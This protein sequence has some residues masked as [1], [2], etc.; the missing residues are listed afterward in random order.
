MI[1]AN[2]HFFFVL[3][4]PFIEMSA[5]APRQ[6]N[7][8]VTEA[9]GTFNSPESLGLSPQALDWENIKKETRGQR[10]QAWSDT[11]WPHAA[12]GIADR[13][14]LR[15]T[16]MKSENLDGRNVLLANF[17]EQYYRAV[18]KNDPKELALL[19]PAEKYDFL[20][21]QKQ[22]PADFITKN[23]ALTAKYSGSK[24]EKALLSLEDK[25]EILGS[26]DA[27]Y[28]AVNQSYVTE[29]KSSA[30]DFKPLLR[31]GSAFNSELKNYLPVTSH[32]W[33]L[34]LDTFSWAH[35]DE[36][37]WMGIC[38]GWSPAAL[39]EAK[40]KQS[41]MVT[42]GKRKI[43]LTEG[44]IRGLL[45]WTWG[46][47]FPAATLGAGIRCDANQ[48]K[49]IVK[50]KRVV[51]GR[52]C[53]G[54]G[55]RVGHCVSA[56][57]I[58]IGSDN[59]FANVPG[60]VVKFGFDPANRNSHEATLRNSLGNAYF[61][62]DVKSLSN[63]ETKRLL[64]QLTQSCRD[65][66]PGLFHAALVDLVA[67]KKIGF[68]VDADRYTQV[69]NQPVYAYE[70]TY[71][72]ILKRD[73]TAAPAGEPVAIVEVKNDPYAKFRSDNA[74]K[75]VQ[76]RTKVIYAAENGPFAIYGTDGRKEIHEEIV[77]DYTLEID[78]SGKIIGGEWGLLPES[79]EV[80]PLAISN[81]TT[82][83]APDFIWNYPDNS[84]PEGTLMNYSLIKKIHD[85]STNKPPTGRF[86]LSPFV[87][88]P[89]P[90]ADCVLPE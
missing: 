30:P 81:S 4:L 5:C 40:P 43:L 67:R 38:N 19:S 15:K 63:G 74:N 60:R 77:N 14:V 16:K 48:S 90:Y 12:K 32:D 44:D 27:T 87:K 79:P 1:R 20:V 53:E 62:A 71:L 73:G 34:W 49:T 58:Y 36:W 24:A 70:M 28:K 59:P 35:D 80:K 75:I 76:V 61:E 66:N 83:G 7:S 22:I 10:P 26:A 89:L 29:A 3:L 86:D 33:G 56:N 72:P 45:S 65:M 21:S 18:Q 6:F 64:I 55:S 78:K 54:K 52:L 57:T 39:R 42:R 85:C 31:D 23:K 84:R 51:D 82:S 88:E 13:Y 11:W 25:L 17:V 2:R 37:A 46:W 50:E 69:W 47:Q 8:Q 9:L 68:V 41:V